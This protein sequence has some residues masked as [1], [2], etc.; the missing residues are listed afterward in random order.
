MNINIENTASA[1]DEASNIISC[2]N[3]FD[4]ILGTLSYAKQTLLQVWTSGTEIKSIADNIDSCISEYEN[5]IL[6][7]M[8]KLASGVIAYAIATEEL[9]S[10]NEWVNSDGTTMT[11]YEATE[12]YYTNMEKMAESLLSKN[13]DG[14][15]TTLNG[16]FATYLEKK[17]D[18]KSMGYSSGQEYIDSVIN[19]AV[20]NAST[21]REKSVAAVTA[22]TNL[23]AENGVKLNYTGGG[24]HSQ[25]VVSNSELSSGVDCSGFVS[26]G[27]QNGSA[28]PES[29]PANGTS[30]LMNR[31]TKVSNVDAQAGDIIVRHT[32]DA[33][34]K[35]NGGTG[36][37]G[38][39]LKN[40]PE[41]STML[42]AEAHSNSEGIILKEYSYNDLAYQGYS[43]RDMSSYY[44]DSNSA[45]M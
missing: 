21:N 2:V 44:G 35:V 38:F 43:I 36:H 23:A 15:L 20:A 18:L 14:S 22:I 8:N 10:S 5:K 28:P 40:N 12:A 4:S 16:S 33:A 17:L 6:K 27:V 19:E 3:S 37:T 1:I 7:A 41:S 30:V 39:I 9:A 11:P 34:D 13:E 29:F 42:I 26:W 31:G 45:S 24:G 32:Y 25:T